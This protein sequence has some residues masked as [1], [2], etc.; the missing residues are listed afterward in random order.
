[1]R[2]YLPGFLFRALL[3]AAVFLAPVFAVLLLPAA[4]LALVPPRALRPVWARI[5]CLAAGLL[6]LGAYLA[7]L[8][9]AVAHRTVSLEGGFAGGRAAAVLIPAALLAYGALIARGPASVS[10]TNRASPG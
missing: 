7:A 6:P 5:L 4:L 1:M 2:A 10:G 8:A 3:L 9:F